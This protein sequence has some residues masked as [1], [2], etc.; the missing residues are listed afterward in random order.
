MSK[1]LQVYATPEIVVTFD[2]NICMHSGVCLRGAPE[3][4]DVRRP[5]WVHAEA[6]PAD[7]V[8]AVVG[9]CPSGALQA[10]RSGHPPN[11]VT[12]SPEVRLSATRN[13]PLLVQGAVTLTRPDGT[14]ESRSGSFSLCRC[15]QTQN[16]PFCDGSHLRVGFKSP[17]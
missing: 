8:A 1:R 5:D 6:A 9:R 13:G 14:A 15:G 12:V 17:R 3:V 16:T 2:P 11:R 7:E 10:V 4:F